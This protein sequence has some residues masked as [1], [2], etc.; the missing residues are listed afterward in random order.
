MNDISLLVYGIPFGLMLLW[1]FRW[2]RTRTKSAAVQL[3]E[4]KAS[5]L[6]EPPSLHPV[7]DFPK[8]IGCGACA[9]VCP[10]HAIGLVEAKP[11][12]VNAAHCIGHGACKPA[13]PVDAVKLVFGTARRG[14]DIP[15]VGPNFETNI[16]GLFIAGE[17]GGMGLVHKSV[18][19]GRQAIKNIMA[20]GPAS[21]GML[22]LVII[23]AGPAGFSATINA[24]QEKLN[25]V[26]L[27]QEDSLGGAVYHY[28]RNK[29]TMT[30]PM[31]LPIVGKV[32]L[33]EVQKEK[34]LEFWMDIAKRAD[35]K[36]NFNERMEAIDQVEGGFKVRSTKH[37][38]L[39]KSVLLSIGRRGTPRTLG[40]KDELQPKVVYRLIDPAQYK[41]MHVMVVGG[42]DSAIE[43]AMACASE[44]G[45]TVTLSYRGATFSRIKPGNRD[46]LAASEKSGRVKTILDSEVMEIKPDV[47]MLKHKAKLLTI[48]NE[49]LIVCAG[50]ILPT[51]L[52]KKLGVAI[53]THYGE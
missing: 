13:C 30:S 32:K 9:K 3:N 42:G 33:G 44:E 31:E 10:E 40:V 8:C 16:P 28:P 18:E 51:G 37:E 15:Q 45:T 48:P 1:Y 25:F 39:A 14:Q 21:G 52:L 29:I 7:F 6:N 26:T 38:Y 36:F 35:L 11:Y 53:E 2:R 17:L 34:L 19:Q 49:A 27:E 12:L 5:G 46:R 50:G 41:G 23:G 4:A 22:D 43:A 47:V 24:K 20:R